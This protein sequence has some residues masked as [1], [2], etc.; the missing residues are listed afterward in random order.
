MAKPKM[1][2]FTT[3]ATQTNPKIILL[4]EVYIQQTELTTPFPTLLVET[5]AETY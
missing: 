2:N 5:V 1:T 3:V 4:Q